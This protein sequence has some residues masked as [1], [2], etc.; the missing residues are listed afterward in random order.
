MTITRQQ[1]DELR[2]RRERYGVLRWHDVDGSRIVE[3]RDPN[4]NAE[5]VHQYRRVDGREQR[6]VL[7]SDHRPLDDGSP[8]AEHRV[9]VLHHGYH[10][11]MDELGGA[12]SDLIKMAR[13]VVGRRWRITRAEAAEIVDRCIAAGVDPR[14]SCARDITAD[15]WVRSVRGIT[16]VSIAPVGGNS[17]GEMR[18]DQPGSMHPMM[19]CAITLTEDAESVPYL[20]HRARRVLLVI[21]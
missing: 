19:R 10:P 3:L 9:D 16:C 14:N 21:D 1:I 4:D 12:W 2:D 20:R 7:T 6:R 13:R 18:Y 17:D 5:R 8:W 11:I 15:D